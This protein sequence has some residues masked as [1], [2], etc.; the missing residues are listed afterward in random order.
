MP[1]KKIKF[2]NKP[3]DTRS[4]YPGQDNIDPRVIQTSSP[5]P[6]TNQRP[7][8]ARVQSI[9]YN[10]AEYFTS[11]D[12][13]DP[14]PSKRP[15][16]SSPSSS[17]ISSGYESEYKPPSSSCPDPASDVG[18]SAPTSPSLP[19]E[20]DSPPPSSPPRRFDRIGK[21]I[22]G[23]APTSTSQRGKEETVTPSLRPDIELIDWIF[24]AEDS[25]SE[26]EGWEDSEADEVEEFFGVTT[27]FPSTP[28]KMVKTRTGRKAH[29]S[30][31]K[32]ISP[33]KLF[34][35]QATYTR[36][37]SEE[38]TESLIRLHGSSFGALD[39]IE[40]YR[41]VIRAWETY[42]DYRL[43]DGSE[44]EA[45]RLLGPLTP[46]RYWGYSKSFMSLERGGGGRR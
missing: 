22:S 21:T 26:S 42:L 3:K 8:R 35:P 20:L 43:E 17:S 45:L 30:P 2:I 13:E 25:S 34:K 5:T 12:I 36:C 6:Q 32:D 33:I 4:P 11:L 41:R 29:P 44:A 37:F 28:R 7:K 46:S 40:V 10:E 23:R 27:N 24:L 14:I 38:T 19:M 1:S 15:R 16:N 18:L 9:R 39:V 31:H